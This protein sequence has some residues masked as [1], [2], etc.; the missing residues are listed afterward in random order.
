MNDQM[1]LFDPQTSGGLLLGVPPAR[2]EQFAQRAAELHQPAW[3]IG[4]A[5]DGSGIRVE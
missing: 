3:I 5:R 2:V 1:M 4:E